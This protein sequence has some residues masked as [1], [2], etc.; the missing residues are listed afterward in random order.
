MD[1]LC[2]PSDSTSLN[3]RPGQPESGTPSAGWLTDVPFQASEHPAA[4][5]STIFA[6]MAAHRPQP[7][8]DESIST[9]HLPHQDETDNHMCQCPHAT[10]A[11][12][13]RKT[14][15]TLRQD[16]KSWGTDP[17]LHII[18]VHGVESWPLGKSATVDLT[19]PA[20]HPFANHLN[21][22]TQ[23]QNWRGKGACPWRKQTK[24]ASTE[25]S[26]KSHFPQTWFPSRA[27]QWKEQ[28][29]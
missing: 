12:I 17:T 13:R 16:L 7:A 9:A 5:R 2:Q 27:V 23:E 4:S 24:L 15:S 1:H 6:Q 8:Q 18:F 3:A 28:K 29:C 26:S 19:P 25:L 20:N 10:A 21:T 14:I 22:A 11:N